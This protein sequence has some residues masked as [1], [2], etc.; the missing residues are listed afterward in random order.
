MEQSL[1]GFRYDF[2]R[3]NG[4]CLVLSGN[5]PIRYAQLERI[6]LRMME[7]NDVPGLLR[8]D[9][10]EVDREVRLRYG[11]TGKRMLLQRVRTERLGL[12][13]YWRLLYEMAATIEQSKSYM[14]REEGFWLHEEFVFTDAASYDGVSLLYV[15]YAETPGKPPVREQ[16]RQLALLLAGS[17]VSIEGGEF[18]ALL[19][20]LHRDRFEFGEV[21]ELLGSFLTGEL[22]L[23][24]RDRGVEARAA[25]GGG[26]PLDGIAGI[27]RGISSGGGLPLADAYALE[28]DG[29]EA[30]GKKKR[31]S[32]AHA[33]RGEAVRT[34]SVSEHIES[35]D[36]ARAPDHSPEKAPG[37][38]RHR[39][40]KSSQESERDPEREWALRHDWLAELSLD[41]AAGEDPRR[42]AEAR[43]GSRGDV[44]AASP[45]GEGGKTGSG[46][47]GSHG[48]WIDRYSASAADRDDSDEDTSTTD[49]DA[50]DRSDVNAASPLDPK[51]RIWIGVIAAALL[52]LLWSFYPEHAPDGAIG[53]WAGLTV[54]LLDGV[55]VAV[56]LWPMLPQ[57]TK[58][59]ALAESYRTME[60][61][62]FTGL[63]G[64]LPQRNLPEA[65]GR[66]WKQR[67]LEDEASAPANASGFVRGSPSAEA[68]AGRGSIEA[69]S[70]IAG[71]QSG[72]QADRGGYGFDAGMPTT[73]TNLSSIVPQSFAAAGRFDR[74]AASLRTSA[75]WEQPTTLLQPPEATVLLQPGGDGAAANADEG[76]D[77]RPIL[78]VQ[79]GGSSEQL[80]IA[81][82]RFVIGREREAADYV[83]D[84]PGV[85]KL[86]L[87][88][89][90]RDDDYYAKDLG[91]RN[92]TL[93]NDEPMVPY[94]GYRLQ[95]GDALQIVSTRFVFRL[96]AKP[97]VGGG[98]PA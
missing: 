28:H 88:L 49:R 64:L 12:Q 22:P 54:L 5:E 98:G 20:M 3:H 50:N 31:F 94:K 68:A 56:V 85:S 43:I 44:A 4:V 1:Y 62:E 61:R 40:R 59:H 74:Y 96:P 46:P 60:E 7:A 58:L 21:R 47:F 81:T 26:R 17:I 15:P 29:A 34:G 86:H 53:V 9:V 57:R 70:G 63:T 16:F 93:L 52:L 48:G 72:A 69:L 25:H 8:L 73:G 13:S 6:E 11:I 92:G 37:S 65:K 89:L 95:D 55:F 39:S 42:R 79:R 83:D 23:P 2:I 75:Y 71:G 45:A 30:S 51:R 91:S 90:R 97:V 32:W 19:A 78:E 24:S 76:Q 38:K 27:D 66:G 18:S 67:G 36:S 84:A 33:E 41:R 82:D 10:E 77:I 87:E 14:L 35:D 80:R